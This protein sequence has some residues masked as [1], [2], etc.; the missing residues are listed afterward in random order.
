M[1]LTKGD[2]MV[3]LNC[4]GGDFVF[5]EAS[6][7]KIWTWHRV[8]LPCE[9]GRPV[10]TFLHY[11]DTIEIVFTNGID[12]EATVNGK[13]VKISGKTAIYIAP[14]QL[15]SMIYKEGGEFI[16]VLHINLEIL[17]RYLNIRNILSAQ[18]KSL[19]FIPCECK[20][21]DKI[22]A[23]ALIAASEENSF[24]KR[25]AA[26]L[27][28]INHLAS[29]ARSGN[30]PTSPVS[31]ASRFLEWVESNYHRKIT[32]NDAAEFFGYSKNYF[33]RWLK[34]S[35]GTGFSEFLNVVRISHACAY[36]LDGYTIEA[37][38][39]ICG[40]SDPS[41]FIK[42]FKRLRGTTPKKYLAENRGGELY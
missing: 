23:V 29:C 21:F 8:L 17:E 22:Y 40:F 30:N 36:L 15:H 12:G 9:R 34:I 27:E 28:I 26:T 32:M 5:K 20:D 7:Q 25:V 18:G 13:S 1:V 39:E 37:T 6:N 31:D 19:E 16:H 3:K 42:V 24:D 4:E 41:Y 33:C 35:V 38:A 14:K 11:G 2:K 10:E